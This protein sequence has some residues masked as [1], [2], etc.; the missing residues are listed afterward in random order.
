MTK[1]IIILA[2]IFIA[3]SAF[4]AS[5]TE[6]EPT[7]IRQSLAGFPM[8]IGE[9]RGREA[10]FDERVLQVLK[11]DDYL[12]RFYVD[13]DSS[14]GLYI[15][16]YQTQRQGSTIHSPLNCLPAAGWNALTRT[17]LTIPIGSSEIE[18]NRITIE[19]GLERQVV[20]YWYQAHG[21]VVANEY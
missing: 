1:R 2:F 10:P 11:V 14:L 16:F 19:K 20:L 12:S 3:G 7:M 18:V 15:G 5:A 21:R 13:G 17:Y 9:W 6:T 4:L 8:Q